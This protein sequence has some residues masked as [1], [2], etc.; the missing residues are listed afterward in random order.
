MKKKLKASTLPETLVATIIIVAS[1]LALMTVSAM[2]S[3]RATGYGEYVRMRDC[4]DSVITA[5]T[6][7][8]QLEH[9]MQ[10]DW[11]TLTLTEEG[12]EVTIET[13]LASGRQYLIHYLVDGRE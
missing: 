10:R 1:F 4:R 9:Q 6:D 7:G 2:L 12:E 8:R 3:R 5:L 11:G 13:R